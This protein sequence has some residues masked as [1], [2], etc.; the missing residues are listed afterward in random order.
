[1]YIY[2]VNVSVQGVVVTS[3]VCGYAHTLAVTDEGSLYAWG[4]NSY[5]QVEC[6]CSI[7]LNTQVQ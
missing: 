6:L 4:A 5:G 3:V 7:L 1:M 2:N